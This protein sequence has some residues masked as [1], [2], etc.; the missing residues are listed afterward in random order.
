MTRDQAGHR[1]D[2]EAGLDY[3]EAL[4]WRYAT[5]KYDRSKR[6]APAQLDRIMEAIRLA[7]SSSGLQ[8]YEVLVISGEALKQELF[9]A[10]WEQSRILD[11]SH[12]LVFAVWDNYTPDRI[13]SVYNDMLR[14]RNEASGSPGFEAYRSGLLAASAEASQQE[15][16][17]NAARQAYV[18]LGFA[19]MAAALDKLDSTPIEGFDPVQYDRILNLSA[20]GLRSVVALCL[21]YRNAETDWLLDLKKIRR[22]KE[23]LFRV[24][25]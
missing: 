1:A 14:Q 13:N 17:E 19:M 25:G 22:A 3:I 4:H 9:P 5:K 15:N 11:C 18:A 16:F 7:P 24:V 2:W 21:G 6:V 8:P 10:S 20:R 23:H 12:L